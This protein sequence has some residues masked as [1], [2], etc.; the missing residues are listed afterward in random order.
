VYW[1]D[2]GNQVLIFFI[3]AVS[4]NLLMGYA[5]QVSIA[6]AAF[7]AIG[8][9]AAAYLAIND[10]W[11]F[12]P[13]VGI[14]MAMALV[15]G[16]IVSLPALRLTGDYLILLT[17]AV[18]AIILV[19]IT[20]VSQL[21]G[22]Y[23][24]VGV[25]TPTVFGLTIA[26]PTQFLYLF[27]VL[28]AIVL[29]IC[30]AIARSRFGLVLRGI[31]D[32]QLATQSLGKNVFLYKMLIFGITS[33]FAGL[34]GLLLAYYN[35]TAS[36][37]LYGFDQS[38]AIVAAVVIGGR[39][40][41]F[42]SLLGA[43]IVVGT[44]PVFEKVLPF[45][46]DTA[47]LARLMFYGLTLVVIM[48][49]RPQGLLPEGVSVVDLLRRGLAAVR[50]RKPAPAPARAEGSPASAAAVRSA[51]SGVVPE[52]AL[53][54]PVTGPRGT[55]DAAE[56][57][58]PGQRAGSTI[59]T[60]AEPPIGSS[61]GGA[62]TATVVA[63]SGLSKAFGG[64]H[65]VQDLE[66]TVEKGRVTGLIG[67]N[68]AGKTTIFNLLTGTIRP[69]GG[70]VFLRGEDITGRSLNHIA[71]LGMLR[72]FQDVRVF[73]NLTPLENVLLAVREAEEG[74][75]R[76]ALVARGQADD[77]H[78]RKQIAM[79]YLEFVGLAEKAQYAAGSL[80]FGEQKLVALARVLA[81]EPDVLLLDEPA[82]GI[83][84]F[85]IERM[86]ELVSRLR[87]LG[88]AICVVEHNLEVIR[89][90]ADRVYFLE[91]GT[92]TAQGTMDELSRDKR[93]IEAY[94]GSTA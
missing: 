14:G 60:V 45:S 25:P 58:R 22:Q 91:S 30:A 81:A 67:P 20:G 53:R 74:D 41:L 44:Q 82:S 59:I 37:G 93:L 72:S 5:G 54:T 46:P 26:T 75:T 43:I 68:G 90:V 31:R 16:L 77:H 35:G 4:L 28:G 51:G 57:V 13:S 12:F 18:Q 15:A 23:G 11:S 62:A 38:I 65:A 86:V 19:A 24:L 56:P 87:D 33:A 9:Y 1:V 80:P 27:L 47:A 10:G 76:A 39:G 79:E 29:A 55:A 7:G 8:G 21:G 70:K 63:V 42:G 40:N 92:V 66:M 6:H 17:L 52:P 71:N 84:K 88:L 2:I 32:D 50:G 83:D 78:G 73:A 69:D 94:F 34:A 3:Y 36:P 48:R 85:W 61:N 89:A 49:L 64:I